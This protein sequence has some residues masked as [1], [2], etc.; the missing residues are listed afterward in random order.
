MRAWERGAGEEVLLCF[1]DLHSME[2]NCNFLFGI[3]KPWH[4]HT[5]LGVRKR[6][7]VMWFNLLG[8]LPKVHPLELLVSYNSNII[9]QK[10]HF[11]V[12]WTWIVFLRPQISTFDNFYMRFLN[13]FFLQCCSWREIQHYCSYCNHSFISFDMFYTSYF[14]SN[15][16]PHLNLCLG[17]VIH[18]QLANCWWLQELYFLFFVFLNNTLQGTSLTRKYH[19]QSCCN[20]WSRDQFLSG[21]AT[22][23]FLRFLKLQGAFLVILIFFWD[24]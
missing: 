20:K 24:S 23:S 7:L 11:S 9:H 17:S 15:E 12:K 10:C 14:Q 6:F 13:S 8:W 16:E 5:P 4:L 22:L 3:C 18:K 19:A 2:L 1:A 21:V